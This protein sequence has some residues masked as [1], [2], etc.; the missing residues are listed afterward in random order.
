MVDK[1]LADRVVFQF[2]R[3]VGELEPGLAQN[4][5]LL[6]YQLACLRYHAMEHVLGY[7]FSRTVLISSG[8]AFHDFAVFPVIDLDWEWALNGR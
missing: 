4:L 2:T 7:E 8:W 3:A 1:L 6:D 5:G